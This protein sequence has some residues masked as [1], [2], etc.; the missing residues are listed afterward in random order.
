[1]GASTS[2][3]PESVQAASAT[4][5]PEAA[6]PPLECPMHQAKKEASPPSDC[7]MH[8]AAASPTSA[9][10][11]LP[12]HQERAYE[13]V[14]CP[15]K[16]GTNSK[17][18]DDI[19]PS[20]MMPPPNQQPAPDQPFPLSVN[21]E[22]SHIPMANSEKY[23]VYPSEQMFW[24]AMLRKGWRW[25]N[26]DISSKDMTNIINIHNS[27][28]EQAWQEILKWEA[29]HAKECPCG[30]ALIR[31]GGK[32]KE[33]SPRARIRSWMG[34]ELPFDRHDWIVNRCGKEVRYVIDYYDG[35]EVDKT[36]YKFTIL[37]VRPAFDSL[38]AV[39]DRMK[40]AWWRWTS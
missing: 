31:F 1:M 18:E 29:L 16:G 10:S 19:D 7:P 39:W 23:W 6:S 22:E 25:R 8:Q 15:M 26:E 28:N 14:Q 37:D 2:K 13:Y 20:N 30:P 35:G 17:T 4:A 33:Y 38:T 5:A 12:K 34:Y 32:A 3:L 9:S 40:V 36:T 21:R 11:S 24:N 27:N